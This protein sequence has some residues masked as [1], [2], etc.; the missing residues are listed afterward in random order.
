MHSKYTRKFALQNY[1]NTERYK[2]IQEW[3]VYLFLVKQE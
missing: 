2:Y 3:C 1:E